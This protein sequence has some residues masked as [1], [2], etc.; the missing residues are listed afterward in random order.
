MS[1]ADRILLVPA[2]SDPERDRVAVAWTAAGGEILRLDR[3]WE[4]PPLDA[5]RVCLYGADAFCLVLAQLLELELVSPP[6]DLIARVPAA[7]RQRDVA[8]T[9]LGAL[10]GP[11]PR[12]VKPLVPKQFAAGVRTRDALAQITAGLP[13]DTAVI[14]SEVVPLDAEARSFVL[15]GRVVSTAIYEGA[16]DPE[17]AAQL[18]TAIAALP[19]VPRTCVIDT[20]LIRGRGWAF[21]EANATWGAGLNG[22]DPTAAVPCIAAA[23]TKP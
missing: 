21:L 8:I 17:A 18:A 5:R 13:D 10:A 7:Q 22:C 3:F 6:D 1:A 16:G 20:C 15:D 19:A 12:F 2:K 11:L 4:P 9:T 23:T 14:V